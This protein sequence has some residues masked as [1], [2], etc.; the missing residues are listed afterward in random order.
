M[1]VN[2]VPQEKKSSSVD[3]LR[4]HIGIARLNMEAKELVE[5]MGA[6]VCTAPLI[7]V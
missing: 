2:F 1:L 3:I 5:W 7:P 4:Y 6:I